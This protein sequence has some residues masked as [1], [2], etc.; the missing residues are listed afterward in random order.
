M[1]GRLLNRMDVDLLVFRNPRPGLL[2]DLDGRF[3]DL[4]AVE[5]EHAIT[6]GLVLHHSL[7]DGHG[8]IAFLGGKPLQTNDTE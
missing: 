5:M 6:V 2:S 4:L 3:K 7:G 8:Y 1:V